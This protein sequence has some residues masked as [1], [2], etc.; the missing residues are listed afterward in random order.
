MNE[1]E[2]YLERAMNE[3]KKKIMKVANNGKGL[4]TLQ[5]T[6]NLDAENWYDCKISIEP[7]FDDFLPYIF[8]E[9]SDI[10]SKLE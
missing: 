6:V 3:A 7:T 10:P 1:F 5:F 8:K 4:K 2:K 9:P